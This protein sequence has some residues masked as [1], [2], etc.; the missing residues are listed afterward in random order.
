MDLCQIVAT[1]IIGYFPMITVS[2]AYLNSEQLLKLLLPE[3]FLSKCLLISFIKV[4]FLSWTR[5]YLQ[6]ANYRRSLI[7]TVL[8]QIVSQYVF[9]TFDNINTTGLKSLSTQGED[10]FVMGII[11]DSFH[12]TGTIPWSIEAWKSFCNIG[13]SCSVQHWVPGVP[14]FL[15]LWPCQ[16]LPS[17]GLSHPLVTYY[18]SFVRSISDYYHDL[19]TCFTEIMPFESCKEWI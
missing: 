11:F 13:A 9:Q 17:Q 12:W 3:C 15:A 6:Y 16:P 14:H 18:N 7:P 4:K 5:L 2:S 1:F 10:T 19:I 8:S